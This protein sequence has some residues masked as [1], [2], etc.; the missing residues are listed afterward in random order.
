MRVGVH[1]HPLLLHLPSPVKLQC[2]LQL[3]GQLH[4][5]C[6][7]SCKDMYSVVCPLSWSVHCN[8]TGDGKY[9]ERGWACTLHPHQ[10]GLILPSWW[11][12][13]QK[14]A[15]A[16]L[17][18]LCGPA[19][20]SSHPPLCWWC[21]AWWPRS[22]PCSSLPP[23]QIT[24]N[25]FLYHLLTLQMK[26]W[27]ESNINVCFLFMYSQKLNCAASLFP[28]HNYNL[29][30]PN[31]YTHISVRDLYI[32]RIEMSILLQLNMWSNPGNI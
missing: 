18:V 11:N 26:G 3:S 1:A 23:V 31:S 16:T 32:S 15:V 25:Y 21:L 5:A 10:P 29:L 17:C 9:N 8:F 14:A 6:F 19:T 20:L 22:A 13:G 24:D 12:V 28:K 4:W 7:I 2:T 27:W 30:S